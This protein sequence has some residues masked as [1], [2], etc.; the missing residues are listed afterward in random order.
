MKF[1]Q[2]R[3]IAEQVDVQEEI[4]EKGP[5]EVIPEEDGG[6]TLDFEPGAINM[7]LEQKHHFDNL[8]DI[9]PDDVLEPIGN[10]MVQNYMDYKA[11]R[12]DWE[13]SYTQGLDF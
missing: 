1:L 8:A 6:V 2:K 11:S 13:Q 5:V 9:L 7:Y 4:E 12:K 10:D 3:K